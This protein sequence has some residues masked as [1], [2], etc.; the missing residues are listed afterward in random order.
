[1]KTVRVLLPILLVLMVNS[2][3]IF[4]YLLQDAPGWVESIEVSFISMGRFWAQNFPHVFW[5]PVWYAGHPMRFSYVPIVPVLTALLGS[6]I[7]SFGRS[8][9][10]ISGMAYMLVPVSLYVFMRSVTKNSWAALVGALGFI[11]KR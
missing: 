5:N 9:H 3:L 7:G 1:M 2:F 10:L 8:Y 6:L 4:P 11:S